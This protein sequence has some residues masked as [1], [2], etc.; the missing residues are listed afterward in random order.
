MRG[1]LGEENADREREQSN[2]LTIEKE[3]ERNWLLKN[4]HSQ[5]FS[6][7]FHD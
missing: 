7:Y 5:L 1:A 3:G 6:R 4:P 2:K